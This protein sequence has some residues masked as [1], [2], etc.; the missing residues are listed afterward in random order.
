MQEK[1]FWWEAAAPIET[2]NQLPDRSVDVAIVGGG[3]TGLNAALTLLGAGKSVVVL[4]A[5]KPGFGASGRNGGMIG[6]M[7]KPGLVGLQSQYGEEKGCAIA[8]EAVKSIDHVQAVIAQN[9]IDCDLTMNGRQY[10]AVLE[11]HLK[12]MAKEAE[13]RMKYLS[14]DEK[15]LIGD[16]YKEDVSTDLYVGGIQQAQ[17]GGLHPGKYVKGLAKAVLAKGGIIVGDCPVR[18]LKKESSGF[19]ITTP[20]GHLK[21]SEVLIATNGYGGNL[22]PFLQKRIMPIGSTMIAT[23]ELDKELVKS[24]FPTSRMITDSRNM[25]S[26]YRPSPDGQ[27]VLLGGRPSILPASPAVQARALKKRLAEIF[28]Q[29][30]TIDIS[31]VWSGYVAY[32]F[33]ALPVIGKHEGLHFA[34]GYCGSGVAMSGYLG[35]KVAL[36]ILGQSEGDTAFDD[37]PFPTRFFYNGRPWFVPVAMV[38]YSLRDRFGF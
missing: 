29:L 17:T 25:L 13:L 38:G 35:H 8:A 16:G 22:T 5:E 33:D 15:I 10:P 9:D 11:K 6:Y 36:K 21:C 34:M 32:G 14:V 31:H 20:S 30:V 26:Y 19:S 37:L 18:D 23:E 27:R 3:Y 24:L 2:D 7:L 28:P 1:P 4:E 12:S